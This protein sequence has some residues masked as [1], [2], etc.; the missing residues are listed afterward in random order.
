MIVCRRNCHTQYV[1][2]L[3]TCMNFTFCKLSFEFCKSL[4]IEHNV[5]NNLRIRLYVQL[6]FLKNVL[7]K[8]EFNPIVTGF[9]FFQNLHFTKSKCNVFR[10]FTGSISYAISCIIGIIAKSFA[11]ANISHCNKTGIHSDCIFTIAVPHFRRKSII[12]YI[13]TDIWI[14]RI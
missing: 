4:T 8:T 13:N 6:H 14:S 7:F 10:L 2:S 5:I 12:K 3:Y 11:K 9:Y 1:R